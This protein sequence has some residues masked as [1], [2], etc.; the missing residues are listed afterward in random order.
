VLWKLSLYSVQDMS[1]KCIVKP[2]KNLK[3]KQ[4]KGSVIECKKWMRKGNRGDD[5]DQS[6]FHACIEI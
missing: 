1:F 4:T 2:R 5:F 6:A 3:K